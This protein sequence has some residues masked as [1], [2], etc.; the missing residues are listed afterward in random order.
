MLTKSKDTK[1]FDKNGIGTGGHWS[2][3]F[4]DKFVQFRV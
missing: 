1:Y 4:A 2:V 3:D